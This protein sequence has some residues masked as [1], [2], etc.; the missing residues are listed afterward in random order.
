M[1]N[2]G[3]RFF[4]GRPS[5]ASWRVRIALA[6]KQVAYESV[7]VDN[8]TTAEYKTVNPMGQ[9]PTLEIDGQRLTQSVAIIEYLEETRPQPGLFPTT[10]LERAR[11]R[12]IVEII[13]S[14][15]Q[16]AHNS[17]MQ[18][19]LA[20]QFGA[21][22]PAIQRWMQP[23]IDRGVRSLELLL[24]K[25]A[26]RFC[27]GDRLSVA[28]VFLYPQMGKLAE[29]GLPLPELPVVTRVVETLRTI[30]EFAGSDPHLLR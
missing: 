4:Q 1:T 15:I 26:G 27:L 16:P 13:N 28:D 24:A 2:P 11:A 20:V 6:L 12:Q 23:W 29:L 7:I 30:P 14:G 18:M 9:V 5:S 21:D 17:M 19:S 10:A 3:T 25:T 8:P 22:G